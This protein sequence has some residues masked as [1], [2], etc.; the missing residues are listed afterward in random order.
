MSKILAILTLSLLCFSNTHAQ[1]KEPGNNLGMT[2]SE[3]KVKFPSVIYW[4]MNGEN[5]MYKY[6]DNMAFIIDKEKGI[7]IT[8]YMF[9][10]EEGDYPIDWYNA[11]VEAFNK[12]NYKSKY[13][14]D[15]SI[16]FFY[17]YFYIYISYSHYNNS[18]SIT[19]KLLPKYR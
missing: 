3:L 9:V 5:Y 18:S 16:T 7:I 12:T 19:Y 10:T 11:T 8:E 4:S 2:L 14:S 1:N 13:A 17:S 15:S 6:D